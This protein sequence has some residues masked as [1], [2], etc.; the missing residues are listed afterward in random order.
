MNKLDKI[1]IAAP[2]AFA[3][4]VPALANE[5][6]TAGTANSDVVNAMTT[7]ANDMKATATAI[8]PVAL[9][10]VGLSMVVIFGIKM[11]RRVSGRG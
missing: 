6:A 2:I 11:F 3:S 10:V 7:V 5:G 4:A 8:L 9:T 1:L